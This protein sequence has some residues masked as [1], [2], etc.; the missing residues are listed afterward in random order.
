MPV[1]AGEGAEQ[2]RV[3]ERPANVL[4][5]EF[6]GWHHAGV[7]R[8]QRSRDRG[9][10][11]L[12]ERAI[13]VDEEVARSAQPLEHVESVEERRILYDEGVRLEDRLAQSDFLL[14]DAAERHHWGAGALGT[15]ARECLGVFTLDKRRD[16]E[17]LGCGDDA[18]AA[19]SVDADLEHPQ[20]PLWVRAA[21][22]RAGAWAVLALSHNRTGP[23]SR[24]VDLD[25]L[26]LRFS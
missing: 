13:A 7:A 26:R 12:G 4:E 24:R 5:G 20:V 9:E 2:R 21:T 15:E 10:A 23:C 19:P 6:G 16:R 18:L 22:S 17:K 14:V 1:S 11:E 3:G 8:P 25:Q